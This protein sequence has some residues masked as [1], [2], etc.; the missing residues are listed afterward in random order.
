MCVCIYVDTYIYIYILYIYIVTPPHELHLE[1]A[2]HFTLRKHWHLQYILH[3][4]DVG[5]TRPIS[6]LQ[7]GASQKL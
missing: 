1:H 2:V 4:S 7:Q 3:V 6:G 5:T